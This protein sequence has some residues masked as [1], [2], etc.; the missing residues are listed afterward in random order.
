MKN[1]EVVKKMLEYCAKIQTYSKGADER[2]FHTTSMVAEACVLNFLQIGELVT[3]L[4][5]EFMEKNPQIPWIKIKGFRN[6]LVHD[7]DNIDIIVVWDIINMQLPELIAK[8]NAILS[9]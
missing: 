5:P 1:K 9:S 7:Y 8:L 6:R 3:K 2:Q 4:D